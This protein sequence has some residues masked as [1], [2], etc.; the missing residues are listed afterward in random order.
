MEY[1]GTPPTDAFTQSCRDFIRSLTYEAILACT[2]YAP[3]MLFMVGPAAIVHRH[4][5]I[6]ITLHSLLGCFINAGAEWP[7]DP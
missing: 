3:P 4:P 7:E 1:N 5:V 2:V 6:L